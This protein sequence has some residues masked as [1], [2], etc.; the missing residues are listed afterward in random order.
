ME[1][2]S[3]N[4]LVA[5]LGDDR[6]NAN[7]TNFSFDIKDRELKNTSISAEAIVNGNYVEVT[8][9]VDEDAEGYIA[10]TINGTTY[11]IELYFGKAVFNGYFPE[12][13]YEM[14]VEYLGDEW[15]NGNSTAV[16]F[17]INKAELE[18]TTID[19]ISNITD[20]E[21]ELIL[22]LNSRTNGFVSIEIDDDIDYVKVNNGLATYKTRLAYGNYTA[23][24]KYLGDDKFNPAE[25]K[26]DVSIPDIVLKDPEFELLTEV[27]DNIL[28]V[29]F[30]INP[31]AT[32]FIQLHIN[33]TVVNIGISDDPDFV[34]YYAY[35]PNGTYNI[36]A[37]YSGDKY[38]NYTTKE[39]IVE[40]VPTEN[41]TV[42]ASASVDGNIVTV[43]AE[44]GSKATGFVEFEIAGK[45]YYA[46]IID[47]K[48]S[49]T[50]TFDAGVYLVKVTYLGDERFNTAN[51]S[52]NFIIT[53]DIPELK[54]TTIE[55]E[56]DVD[57]ND[58]TITAK[59]NETA[60]GLIAFDID[61]EIIYLPVNNGEAVGCFV[62][63]IGSYNVKITYMGDSQFN[64][65]KLN[66]EFEVTENTK[67]E[68]IMEFVFNKNATGNIT[69]TVNGVNYTAEIIDGVAKM[70][71]SNLNVSG[72]EIK[73]NFNDVNINEL[74]K[75]LVD[76][77]EYEVPLTNGTASIETKRTA[78]VIEYEDMVTKTIDTKIDGRNGE[79]FY[80]TLKDA[81]GKPM[82][83]TP[84]QIGFNGVIYDE[85]DGI[86][87]DENGT[88]RL[89]INLGYKGVY[90]FA[91]C[92]LGD[93]KYNAS[94]AVAKITVNVQ[95]PTLTVPNKSYKV[96]AKIKTLTAT[97]KDSY[98]KLIP[99][100]IVTF[101]VNGKTYKATT[102][103]KGL[104][105]VKVSLS[106]KKIYSFTVKYAGD[107]TYSAVKK[108]AKVVIK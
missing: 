26:I 45:K 23:I 31:E 73:F 44:L 85:E 87:T 16:N 108:I 2:G 65:A 11:N 83:N 19:I 101:T 28:K 54:N 43:T 42:S 89:Q 93:E 7:S 38:F 86:V 18:N 48:A 105:S 20:D 24:V 34:G 8:A 40:I 52:C 50:N 97:L 79:Y 67:V 76:G 69:T 49:F 75:V 46:P 22:H 15:F 66:K 98:G 62:L 17:T 80:F 35:L 81:N 95:T 63:P 74:I 91:I 56:I 70:T 25:A 27:S 60:N 77:V 84:M 64:S 33:N 92:Y 39:K 107:S 13:N 3:Y 21:L 12:G 78:T 10:F 47:S 58:V 90:T 9:E 68:P 82:A 53:E 99:N 30:N 104:A 32:G 88:A 51:T 1:E 57:G 100:K 41:T 71:I 6:F 102:N 106:A 37:I 96:A 72:D 59:V 4:A 36:T 103:A 5:Y 29:N 61:G 14:E 94:F 55:A